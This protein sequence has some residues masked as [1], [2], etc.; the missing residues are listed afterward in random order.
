[1]EWGGTSFWLSDKK[2]IKNNQAISIIG[3]NL[4]NPY[5]KGGPN[6]K[7]PETEVKADLGRSYLLMYFVG[8][9]IGKIVNR[10]N[11]SLIEMNIGLGNG[12]YKTAKEIEKKWIN[13]GKLKLIYS[14]G[15][16]INRKISYFIEDADQY[17]GIGSSLR[18]MKNI[19]LTAT[20]MHRV[21][22]D[23]NQK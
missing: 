16:A 7:H 3:N 11:E 19:P 9:D 23:R 10:D 1:M 17:S 18:P 20:I 15:L 2:N 13:Q 21:L 4:Y 8:W 14:I 12:K 6:G 5:G 22:K